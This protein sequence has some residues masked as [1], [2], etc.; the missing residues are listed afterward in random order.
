MRILRQLFLAAAAALLLVACKQVPT[1]PGISPYKI[2]IQ[3]GN[4]ITQEMMAKL[5]VGM[6]R[7][8]V[9]F[10]L[11]TPLVV[12]PFRTDRWDYIYLFEKAGRLTERRHI[13]VIFKDDK[14]DHIEGDVIPMLGAGDDIKLPPEAAQPA[15]AAPPKEAA[16]DA[17]AEEPKEEK[18]FFGRMLEKIGL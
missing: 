7:S 6:T 11:G 16:K 17:A 10:V 14:L 9:R 2:D 1:L 4:A 5:R 8:Q 3:Q 12:D 18:G 15:T 13:A